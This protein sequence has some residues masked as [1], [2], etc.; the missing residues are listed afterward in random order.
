MSQKLEQL[1]KEL[2]EIVGAVECSDNNRY[3]RP[4]EFHISS[5]RSMSAKRLVDIF[6]EMRL[7]VGAPPRMSD[8]ELYLLNEPDGCGDCLGEG[9]GCLTCGGS[10][11]ANPWV[12]KSCR[13][14]GDTANHERDSRPCHTCNETGIDPEYQCPVCKGEGWRV[15]CERCQGEGHLVV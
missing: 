8:K 11:S 13:G 1:V 4:T 2:F 3:F 12:C 5:C 10:G 9:R 15:D 7:E 6:E 14:T